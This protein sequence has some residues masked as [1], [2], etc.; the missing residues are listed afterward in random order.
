MK[1]V[2]SRRVLRPIVALVALTFALARHGFAAAANPANPPNLIIIFCDDLGYADVGCFGAQGI[3]TPQLDRMAAEG[4]RFTNFHVPQPVCSASRAGLLTGCYPN[5]IGIHM[6]LGPGTRHGLSEGEMT[7]A[8]LVKQKGYATGMVGKWH[9]GSRPP[10]LPTY[11][12]FDDF[13]NNELQA[14]TDGDGRWKLQLPHTY[15]GLGDRPGGRDGLPVTYDM[16]KFPK[17][18]LFDLDHD[19][20]EKT[21][22]A[23]RH[24]AIVRRLEVFAEKM[25]DQ[26]GD[27]LTT[28]EGN[29]LREPGRLAAAPKK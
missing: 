6:A 13:E 18:A 26:L 16:V 14:V 28:R 23:D 12:G 17:T 24:P 21:N 10:L 15:R 2:S 20:G 29:A 25:R 19:I 8:E 22:V 4:R 5:R 1:A 9:L 11:H 3:D 7:L 27:S